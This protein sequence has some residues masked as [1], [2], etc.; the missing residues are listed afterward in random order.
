[1]S[2]GNWIVQTARKY[3]GVS[4]QHLGR[5]TRGLDCVGLIVRVANDLDLSSY[6]YKAYTQEPNFNQFRKAFRECPDIERIAKKEMR[7]GDIVLI[8]LPS[9]PCHAGILTE[10]GIIHALAARGRVCEHRL[11]VDWKR[12]IREVYRFVEKSPK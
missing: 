12:R 4:F 6:D 7:A 1:M 10:R 8:A 5:T 9:F 11:S 3:T 2:D